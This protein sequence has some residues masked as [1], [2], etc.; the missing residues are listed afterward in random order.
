M[1]NLI[2]IFLVAFTLTKTNGQNTPSSVNEMT[3]IIFTS[4]QSEDPKNYLDLV[5][6]VNW[7]EKEWL[8]YVPEKVSQEQ[9]GNMLKE[10]SQERPGEILKREKRFNEIIELGKQMGIIWNQIT[11]TNQQ[12]SVIEEGIKNINGSIFFSH[13]NVDYELKYEECTKIGERW[14]FPYVTLLVKQKKLETIETLE[15]YK[16]SYISNCKTSIEQGFPNLANDKQKS[17]TCSCSYEGI[18]KDTEIDQ[19]KV[20]KEGKL[21]DA[22]HCSDFLFKK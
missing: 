8:P 17:E 11:Y 16:E 20:L 5:P 4:F 2:L 6:E 12:F 10:I 13:N 1:K 15:K 9:L 3:Q 18:T 7:F 14:C 22:Y 19:I 21:Y